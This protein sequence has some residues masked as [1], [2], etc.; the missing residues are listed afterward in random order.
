MIFFTSFCDLPQNEHRRMFP[1][2]WL[3]L[4]LHLCA[5]G[6]FRLA[7]GCAAGAYATRYGLS[8]RI[9][10]G[11]HPKRLAAGICCLLPRRRWSAP[12]SDSVRCPRTFLQLMLPE[13]A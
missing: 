8:P 10:T 7:T 13:T 11:V 1:L 3:M 4:P 2:D 9:H 6:V 5:G 12:A